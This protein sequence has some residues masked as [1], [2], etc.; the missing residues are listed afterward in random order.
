MSRERF[1]SLSF[2]SW[3]SNWVSSLWLWNY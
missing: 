1:K 3:N 2:S